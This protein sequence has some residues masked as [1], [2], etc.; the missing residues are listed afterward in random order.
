M[1]RPLGPA[2]FDA[3]RRLS[4]ARV[5]PVAA[6][7]A[8]TALTAA[9]TAARAQTACSGSR[10]VEPNGSDTANDCSDATRPCATV[11]RAVAAAS[12]GETICVG[13]KAAWPR[14][15]PTPLPCDTGYYC[16]DDAV[17][18]DKPLTIQS[19]GD[20]CWPTLRKLTIRA[21]GVTLRS[22]SVDGQRAGGACIEIGDAA[23]PGV[24]GTQILDGKH[25]DCAQGVLVTA[26]GS[27]A[28]N[29]LRGLKDGG[30][31]LFDNDVHVRLDGIN[32]GFEIRGSVL[33]RAAGSGVVWSP[34]AGAPQTLTIY[35]T[36]VTGSGAAGIEVHGGANATLRL[37]GNAI[38]TSSTAGVLVD[39][40]RLASRCNV[41]RGNATGVRLTN[42]AQGSLGTERFVAQG[43]AALSI[44]ASSA[45]SGVV[46][47]VFMGNAL[48][49]QNAG[50]VAVDARQSWWN[51]Q[52]GPSGNGQPGSGD[53]VSGPV[54]AGD[55]VARAT[56]PLLV[57]RPAVAGDWDSTPGACWPLIA[58]ALAAAN[59]GDLVMI[60]AGTYPEPL[61]V[62]KPVEMRGAEAA[63][64]RGNCSA[65][66]LDGTQAAGQEHQ[67]LLWFRNVAGVTLRDMT[68]AN[69]G[70]GVACGAHDAL[71]T[72]LTLLNVTG[73]TFANLCFRANGTT[74]VKVYGNSTDNVFSRLDIDGRLP[75]PSG[76]CPHVSREG[77]LIDGG[78]TCE[79][80]PGGSADRNRVVDSA[81]ANVVHGAVVRFATDVALSSTTIEPATSPDWFSG[82]DAVGVLVGP[83][84]GTT[85][86]NLTVDAPALRDGIRVQ[87]R[88]RG[89]CL[90]PGAPVDATRTAIR[91]GRVANARGTGV[92]FAWTGGDAGVP[93]GTSVSCVDLTRNAYGVVADVAVSGAAGA[94]GGAGGVGG[95]PNTVR[96]S[97][98]HDNAIAG[99]ENN[100]RDVLP[101]TSNWWGAASGPTGCGAGTG[102]ALLGAVAACPFLAGSPF[103]DADG[104][105]Y[106]ACQGDCDDTRADVHPGAPEPADGI[107]HDCDGV[108]AGQAR[109]AAT[110][111]LLYG[112]AGGVRSLHWTAVA[113]AASYDLVRGDVAALLLSHGDFSGA[114]CLGSA[115]PGA[116]WPDGADPARGTAFWYLVRARNGAGTGT[117]D[118]AGG[119]ARSRDASLAAAAG[120]CP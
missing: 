88:A 60:G 20:V 58:G 98:L 29:V 62:E 72:G 34:A 16:Y 66:V 35:G 110:A 116:S 33:A 114:L 104:D 51:A 68:L 102:D 49:I 13:P 48:A 46:Q 64:G 94:A 96:L 61:L 2:P 117:W 37:E 56:T 120:T 100:A 45:V 1:Q 21:S 74:E 9:P 84:D 112:T 32:D 81:I 109:P 23:H 75:D 42:G 65:T 7:A 24:R 86:T 25:H 14:G 85:L 28:P 5:A 40:A 3:C 108:I 92:R 38:D 115:L 103:V 101:A 11:S 15:A 119:L 106:T 89:E 50:S 47:S 107:D 69:A 76:H 71:E 6:L 54:N 31:Q 44:D 70:A 30:L 55:F 19:E 91:G 105:G 80:G 97:A 12:A 73:S 4:C 36:Q 63:A 111:G 83:A 67:R 113:G 90:T 22:M 17:V 99:A 118:D 77:V 39:G 27:G 95:A 78:T 93:R 52:S 10:W 8:L 57:A 53:A 79:G 18:V 41:L 59:A 87:G 43:G 26:T 82:D